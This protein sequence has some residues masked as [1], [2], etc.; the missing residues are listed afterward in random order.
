VKYL[1]LAVFLSTPVFALDVFEIKAGQNY[2]T[3]STEEL[4]RRVWELEKAV[5]QLQQ[6]VFAM[7]SHRPQPVGDTWVCEISTFGKRFSATGATRAV[8]E[9][10]VT[11]RCLQGSDSAFH[12]SGPRCRQ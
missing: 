12:C 2:R 5:L 4:R 3:Y 7:E 11:E 10:N 1:F 9:H 6:R 8:A